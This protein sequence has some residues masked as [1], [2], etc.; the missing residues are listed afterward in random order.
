MQNA[1]RASKPHPRLGLPEASGRQ[2]PITFRA[3]DSC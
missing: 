1:A 3:T 2:A